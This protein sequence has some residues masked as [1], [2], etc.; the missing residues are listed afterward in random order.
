MKKAHVLAG[1]GAVVLAA[2][3]A[4]MLRPAAQSQTAAQPTVA[5]VL[6][7][8]IIEGVF[9]N[10]SDADGFAGAQANP[11]GLTVVVWPVTPAGVLAPL[12]GNQ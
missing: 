11:A 3:A 5:I 7:G 8:E 10:V 1:A 12:N 2:G 6:S 9:T 4:H